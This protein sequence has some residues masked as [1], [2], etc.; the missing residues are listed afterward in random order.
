MPNISAVIPLY[1][2]ERHVERAVRSVRSQDVSCSELII[3]DDGSTDK[4][5]DIVKGMKYHQLKF[6]T[7]KNQ[8][9]SVARNTGITSATC[10][11]VAFLD[12]DD[13]WR[14]GFLRTISRLITAYPEAGA[15]A[16]SY[17]VVEPD[18]RQHAA[19]IQAIPPPPW[20]GLLPN[21]IQSVATGTSPVWSS[22]VCV[23]KTTFEALGL[24]CTGVRL[25][26]D[27]E[28]WIRI[29]LNFPIAYSTQIGATYYRNA[30][31]RAC[32]IIVPDVDEV[33]FAELLSGAIRDERLD[34]K[35]ADYAKSFICKYSLLN[36]FKCVV[37]GEP[38]RA[39]RI[40]DNTEPITVEQK[41]RK[42]FTLSLSVL[43]YQLVRLIWKT[44]VALKRQV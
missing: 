23:K 16:T 17:N 32:D 18:G 24:F 29:A 7:Q 11:Y 2:K 26:E 12:A 4:S 3:V 37:A 28:M 13:E 14:P 15:Y 5:P 21:Y 1:N 8:G 22:A 9:V 30:E 36:A 33:S 19:N 43:P 6:V 41:V 40:A 10:N 42:L 44:G 20:E 39:R 31:N 25:Y 38:E 35:T 34:P 27:L